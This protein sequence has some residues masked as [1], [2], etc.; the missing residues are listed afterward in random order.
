M[1]NSLFRREAVEHQRTRLWGGVILTQP[2]ATKVAAMVAGAMAVLLVTFLILGDYTRKEK[3]RGYLVPESGLVQIYPDQPGTVTDILVESG[4][5]V[6]AGDI[7][8]RITTD[9]SMAN[10]SDMSALLLEVLKSQKAL[11]TQ[12]TDRA[13]M[14]MKDRREHLEERIE[15]V[16]AQ[17]ARL[18]DQR[19]VQSERLELARDR[20]LA[21][22]SL[23]KEELMSESDYQDRYQLFLDERLSYERIEHSLLTEQSELRSLEFELASLADETEEKV[24]QLQTEKARLDQQII[25]L[26]GDSSYTLQAAIAGTVT[27]MQLGRGQTVTARRPVMAILPEGQVLEADLF[28]PTR[29]IGFLSEGL[30]VDI[31]YDAFP[32]Q[33][34]GSYSG[35]VMQ[36]AR[37]VLS[38]EDVSGPLRIQ[39]PVYRSRVKLDHDGVA[40]YGK[41][42]PLQAGMM[43]EAHVRLD[44]RPLYQWLLKPLY[45]LKGTF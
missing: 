8:A 5:A 13:R 28:V 9:K 43:F 15:N 45:S 44:K 39:E 10:G 36:V 23:R 24:D 40:A 7:L 29:A 33:R 30:P 18:E 41:T 19:A 20:Y 11:V 2:V 4:D 21:L 3:V 17:I 26:E 37:T 32:Y 31:R 38:P 35:E 6:A 34:F 1:S 27:S 12:R 14:L 22:E 42:F 16:K 25:R